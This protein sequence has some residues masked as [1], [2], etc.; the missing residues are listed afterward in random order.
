[1]MIYIK[2]IAILIA[3]GAGLFQIALEYR[4]HDKRTKIHKQVRSLLILLMVMGFFAAAILVVW[5]DRQSEK[6]I[7]ALTDLK[8]G[9]EKA[10]KDSEERELKAIE[11]REKIKVDLSAL[12]AEYNRQLLEAR[13]LEDAATQQRKQLENQIEGLQGQLEPFVRIATNRFPGQYDE[14]IAL[15]KLANELKTLKNRTKKIETEKEKARIQST[16][17]QPDPILRNQVIRRLRA[18]IEKEKNLA[19]SIDCEMGNQ[20]RLRVVNDL[21]VMIKEANIPVK[22]IF[23]QTAY[24]KPPSPVIATFN[25]DDE[26]LFH[27]VIFSFSGYLG[28]ELTRTRRSDTPR[29]TIKLKFNGEPVFFT[30][31]GLEFH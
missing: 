17:Q 19:I 21:V 2:I 27:D 4:W 26:L 23:S 3:S 24:L 6:Q 12:Q 28:G 1:M 18:I 10:T 5:D 13:V 25:P 9:A 7:Q 11:D 20:Q 16:Y 8:S 14:K 29:G 30:N 22:R 15:S 31:T